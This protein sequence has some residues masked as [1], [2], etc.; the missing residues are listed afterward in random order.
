MGIRTLIKKVLNKL[1]TEKQ[2]ETEYYKD[3][4]I[5][6]NHWNGKN[7]NEEEEKRWDIIKEFIE[8]LKFEKNNLQILDLGCGRGWLSNLL[9]NYGNVTAVEPITPV[10]K[11]AKA[12]FPKL[13][14]SSGTSETL[15]KTG[16]KNT[17]DLI[18]SSEVIEHIPDN[19]KGNFIKNISLL[20]RANGYLIITTPRKD[21]EEEWLKYSAP[22]Q[23]IED[24]INEQDLE[25]LI[26][27]EGFETL[28]LKRFPIKPNSNAPE[29]EVYQLWLF[30]KK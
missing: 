25:N 30:Q 12:L 23:P 5:K 15:L 9:M 16:K 28:S 7:P 1:K 4:F 10:A 24:W 26:N 19:K 17:F 11:H 14:V 27:N 13:N 6:N 29:I 8:E 3:L 20:L 22:D 18:V 2:K 21:V